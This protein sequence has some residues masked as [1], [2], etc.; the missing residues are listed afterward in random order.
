MTGESNAA[1]FTQQ[2]MP[3]HQQLVV[4]IV[5]AIGELGGSAKAREITDQVLDNYPDVERLLEMTYPSRPNQSVLI[6]RIAWGRSTAK[7]IGVLEQPSKGMYITTDLGEELLGVS[8]DEAIQ[9]IRDLDREYSRQQR[10]K[11]SDKIQ[12]PSPAETDEEEPSEEV[13]AETDTEDDDSTATWKVQ[14]LDRLHRLTP[15]GFEKFVLYL[16]RR[17]GLELTHIGGSGDEG[18]DGIGTAPLSPVLSSRVA[19]QV[20]RYAPNGKPI[21]RDTVALFQRDAQTKGAERAILV[22]LSRFTDPARKAATSST[23]TVDLI[24]GDRLADL[25]RDDGNS[26]VS[27]QPTVNE[28]WFNK[29]D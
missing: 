7:L 9:R 15:E 18:I 21:G 12:P 29:F 26:G 20:K 24:S 28:N 5:R 13:L 17:Y 14:L 16:L 23:P 8:E 19:V 10:R 4:P 2:G 1:S 22:T 25:I 6:D 11:K 27:L 3:T